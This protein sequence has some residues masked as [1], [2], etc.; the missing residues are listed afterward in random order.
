M[1]ENVLSAKK[2]FRFIGARSEQMAG[3]SL[4]DFSDAIRYKA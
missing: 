2:L 3:K 1:L 4:A